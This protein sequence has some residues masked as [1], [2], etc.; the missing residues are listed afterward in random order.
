MTID[1]VAMKCIDCQLPCV[2]LEVIGC[3][4]DDCKFVAPIDEDEE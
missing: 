2:L 1:T 4:R 3:D